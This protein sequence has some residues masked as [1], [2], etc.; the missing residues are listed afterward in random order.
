MTPRVAAHRYGLGEPDLSVVG[1]R[2]LDWLLGQIGPADAAVGSG[3]VSSL[4]SLASKYE[5]VKRA[6]PAGPKPARP[7]PAADTM[8]AG[9][10]PAARDNEVERRA[11]RDAERRIMA[12]DL[13]SR[14]LTASATRRPFAE[15]LVLF[16][17][18][19]FTVSQANPRVRG[20]AGAFEREAI[21]PHIAGSFETLLRAAVLHPAML[22][23][24]DNQKS[25]GPNARAV[26]ASR[27][28]ASDEQQKKKAAGLNENLARELLE[29]HTLGAESSRPGAAGQVIYGQADV[30]ALARILT[31]WTT[32]QSADA[33][34]PVLFNARQHEPGEKRL[35]GRRYAEGAEALERVLHDL[36]REPATARFLA[37]K[38]LRHFVTDE[39][40]ADWVAELAQAYLQADAQLPALYRA[41]LNSPRAW[42][43]QPAK[44]KTP[45]EFAVSTA[46]L[47]RLEASWLGR[48]REGGIDT[49]G[50][51]L[52]W[53][54]SPAGW[55][56]RAEDWL[57]PDAMWKRIEW[58][59]RMAE[60]QGGRVDARRL[61]R[62]AFGDGLS[63]ATARQIERAAD[64][65]QAL[66]L[67]L[68][69]PEFQ[70]R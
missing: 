69:S 57:G 49:M 40:P 30:Q 50:Q 13:A 67:L 65:A 35:L 64:G 33:D 11:A 34:Q 41:L 15:R 6:L 4:Q 29:L 60:L 58:S 5:L 39:P 44:L 68:M 43:P 46:R 20:L 3:L 22:R 25:V 56:D 12:D 17:S 63:E 48:T 55:S 42:Q 47:L 32:A 21:R 26:M 23:Y 51:R 18:N 19:H 38:L 52:Q 10:A 2:P 1:P 24:L 54:P 7:A 16:W 59:T 36:A 28:R 31:G 66:T 45:E 53:A 14:L 27:E 62:E 61:A 70:R 37:T 8:T 9:Q